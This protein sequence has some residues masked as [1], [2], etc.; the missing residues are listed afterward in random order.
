MMDHVKEV[1]DLF[2]DKVDGEVVIWIRNKYDNDSWFKNL[3]DTI[4]IGG[5]GE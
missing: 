2:W 1:L 5:N 4:S 3:I